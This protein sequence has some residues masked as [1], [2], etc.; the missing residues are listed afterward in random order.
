M[1]SALRT[2][3][4]GWIPGSQRLLVSTGRQVGGAIFSHTYRRLKRHDLL[5]L[6]PATIGLIK[7]F[8]LLCCGEKMASD[9]TIDPHIFLETLDRSAVSHKSPRIWKIVFPSSTFQTCSWGGG[10]LCA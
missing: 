8:G 1:W 9:C 6:S 4:V 3:S 7:T 10:I 5:E 2:G